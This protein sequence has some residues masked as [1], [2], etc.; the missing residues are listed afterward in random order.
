MSPYSSSRR[1]WAWLGL[2]GLCAVVAGT[3][4]LLIGKDVNWDLRNYHYYNAFAFLS[5]RFGWDL[6]P[7]Q[8]QT[9]FN[10]LGDFAF[11]ALVN[12]M[13]GPRSV[14]FAMA[15][16][17]AV[18]AFFLMRMLPPLFAGSTGDRLLCIACA[19]AIGLTTATGLSEL[20]S[21]MN[22]WLSAALLMPGVYFMLRSVG[23]QDVGR[24]AAVAGLLAGFATGL[25]LPNAVFALGLAA[26]VFVA[27]PAERR[28]RLTGLAVL[29]MTTGF[30]VSY[31][32]W[33][34]VLQQ[35]YGSPVFPFFNAIFQSPWYE[36]E[37]WRDRGLGPTNAWEALLI[38]Y[39]VGRGSK[40]ISNVALRDYRLAVL[41]VVG[42]LVLA[43]T[44]WRL[45]RRAGPRRTSREWLA[46]TIFGLVAY[47]IWLA[48]FGVHRYLLPLELVSGALIVAGFVHLI[49]SRIAARALILVVAVLLVGTT[50]KPGWERVPFGDRY[51]AVEA[52]ALEARALVILSDAVPASYAIP[53]FRADARFVAPSSNLIHPEQG[54]RLA[55]A[56]PAL[57]RE[58]EGPLYLLGPRG[59]PFPAWLSSYG[60]ES[61]GDECQVVRSDADADALQVCRLRRM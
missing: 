15:L 25:K 8:I 7:A 47:L 57:I 3:A 55:K 59:Q 14:A 16:P 5:G 43:G 32:W 39:F 51:F 20:G 22:E 12:V 6:A 2:F 40:I 11:Y 21:T 53:S 23:G 19:A 37:N 58:H 54:N 1:R 52:P 42:M 10:P 49:P 38:P 31:G 33:A 26:A 29:G 36:A 35:Q 61:E 41:A 50:R 27:A 56:I 44:I 46:L 13:P 17:T 18:A 34:W 45:V 9:Y 24:G 28:F 4:S 48:M 30:L 60:L